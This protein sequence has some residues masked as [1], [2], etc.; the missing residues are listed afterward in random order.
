MVTHV[1]AATAPPRAATR[2]VAA[3]T[4]D[5]ASPPEGEPRRATWRERGDAGATMVE[6]G[7]MVALVALVALLA[8]TAFGINVNGLIDNPALLDALA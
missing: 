5:A 3:S 2:D 4:R 8:V 6:Y 1:E 7:L